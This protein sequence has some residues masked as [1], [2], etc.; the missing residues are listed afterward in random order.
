MLGAIRNAKRMVQKGHVQYDPN[1][2]KKLI[3]HGNG[4]DIQHDESDDIEKIKTPLS[5]DFHEKPKYI[6]P[7]E[8]I[9]KVPNKW[10]GTT[11]TM[12]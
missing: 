7:N 8:I 11:I 10:G 2:F 3:I 6:N 1:L 4:W 12:E 5:C 9:K